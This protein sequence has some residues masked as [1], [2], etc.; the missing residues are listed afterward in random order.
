MHCGWDYKV[1]QVT[2]RINMEVPHIKVELIYGL[3]IYFWANRKLIQIKI[4]KRYLSVPPCSVN[5]MKIDDS[6]VRVYWKLATVFSI[7]KKKEILTTFYMAGP[8]EHYVKWNKP[9]M[10]STGFHESPSFLSVAI[11]HLD[12]KSRKKKKSFISL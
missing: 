8:R 6:F 1:S 9:G 7:C 3:S 2:M 5:N 12:K 11:K 4:L 10:E